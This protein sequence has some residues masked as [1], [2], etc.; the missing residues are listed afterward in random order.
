MSHGAG[1]A[2]RGG[3]AARLMIGVQVLIL[4]IVLFAPILWMILA[5]FKSRVDIT[6]Y[7]PPFFLPV[8]FRWCLLM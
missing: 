2:D 1:H 3:P 6:K 4:V 7:P 5:S 8:C